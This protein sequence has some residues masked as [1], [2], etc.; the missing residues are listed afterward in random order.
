[1]HG[2]MHGFI[3]RFRDRFRP[4]FRRGFRFGFKPGFR[5]GFW[6]KGK[7]AT[8]AQMPMGQS[9]VVVQIMGGR[10]AT[11]RLNSLGI[12]PGQRITQLSSMLMRGPVAIQ[13]GR[14]QVAIGFGM[15]NRIIVRLD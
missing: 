9:G 10:I 6:P 13:L 8:L 15:A 2:F 1:M 11:N 7:Q 14:V 4:G 3:R 12:R 5:R